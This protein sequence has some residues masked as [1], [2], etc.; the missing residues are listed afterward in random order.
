MELDIFVL[1]FSEN[2][3]WGCGIVRCYTKSSRDHAAMMCNHLAPYVT[4]CWNSLRMPKG[5]SCVEPLVFASES[6]SSHDSPK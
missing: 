3:K 5:P 2:R 1:S 4:W 6:A